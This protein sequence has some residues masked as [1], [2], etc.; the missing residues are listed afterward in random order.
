MLKLYG[1]S[2]VNSVARGNTRDLRILWALEEMQ[3]PFELVGLDHPAHELST[4]AY[5][6]L[7]PFEQVPVIDDDGIVV[8]ESGAILL[9]LAKKAGKLIPRDPAGEAQV[10]RW[11]FAALNTVE[12]PLL[13]ILFLDWG[14]RRDD[15]GAIAQRDRFA[16]WA[17]RQLAALERWLDGREFVATDT[18]TIADILMSHVLSEAK[19][20]S[21]LSPYARVRAYRERCEA[22]PAW[23]RTL[24]RYFARVEAG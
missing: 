21:L 14:E 5:R 3:M 17:H 24:E 19:D 23:R 20:D 10:L 11:C 22:R 16:K 12:L 8:S 2:R 4:V 1:F 9:Y 18:F 6:E 13:S 15:A 7:S